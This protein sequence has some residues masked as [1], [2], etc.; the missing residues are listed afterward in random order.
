MNIMPL[1]LLTN[2]W[3]WSSWS[4]CI[5]SCIGRFTGVSLIITLWNF[6]TFLIPFNV[7]FVTTIIYRKLKLWFCFSSY[8]I[9]L[10]WFESI[11]LRLN[12]FNIMCIKHR[13]LDC[14][15][16]FTKC[17]SFIN[18]WFVY[19]INY[20]FTKCLF[21]KTSCQC[22]HHS[23]SLWS[24]KFVMEKFYDSCSVFCTFIS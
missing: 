15:H 13:S 12:I 11:L 1:S 18:Y 4:I 21:I 2:Y 9:I 20:N 22:N 6:S 19:F 10:L 5:C 14:S 7:S 24:L 17:W 8:V 23:L 3:F 16:L